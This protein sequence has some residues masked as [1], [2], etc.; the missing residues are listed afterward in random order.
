MRVRTGENRVL[1][2]RFARFGHVSR[3]P[4]V[5][6]RARKK[7]IARALPAFYSTP[8]SLRRLVE[9]AAR[10]S[11]SG[12]VYTSETLVRAKSRRRH[13]LT[14][15][16]RD[17]KMAAIAS[18]QFAAGVRAPASAAKSLKA[19]SSSSSFMGARVAA[20]A[21]SVRTAAAGGLKVEARYDAG[22]GVFGNKAG[23]TQLFTEEGLCVPV[24]V[25]AVQAG[26]V[27]TQVRHLPAIGSRTR[28]NL[29]PEAPRARPEREL[30]ARDARREPARPFA[31][32]SEGLGHWRARPPLGGGVIHSRLR[33]APDDAARIDAHAAARTRPHRRS[34]PR[35]RGARGA[36]AA[37]CA[38]ASSRPPPLEKHAARTLVR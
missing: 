19:T 4:R 36:T 34:R 15:R 38:R 26:N 6:E 27:V 23:M 24:T 30:G 22:V 7:R 12:R 16:G 3:A 9:D 33:A 14:A 37:A 2:A 13:T 1:V 5:C 20:P 18:I 8:R 32:T 28:A 21:R 29:P 35:A 17:V 25:I 10:T 31:G 11:C